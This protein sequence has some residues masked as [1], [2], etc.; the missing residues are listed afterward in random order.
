M[1]CL[2]IDR[3]R[4]PRATPSTPSM[5][6]KQ[7]GMTPI[8]IYSAGKTCNVAEHRGH[9]SVDP[10]SGSIENDVSPPVKPAAQFECV[11]YVI[12]WRGNNANLLSLTH[13]QSAR[14]Q[15]TS[16]KLPRL[17]SH[18]HKYGAL[19]AIAG[20]VVG[21]LVASSRRCQLNSAVP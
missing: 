1:A 5:L 2:L 7:F 3:F 11:S 20:T 13:V 12:I 6:W 10:C 4:P 18:S 14:R 16:P 17:S 15:N 19:V 8:I 21:G 9:D